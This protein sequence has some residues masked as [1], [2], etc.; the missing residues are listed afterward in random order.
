MANSVGFI[1]LSPL[2]GFRLQVRPPAG[3]LCRANEG[4][5]KGEHLLREATLG[6]YSE[7]NEKQISVARDVG[8]LTD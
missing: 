8:Y 7:T 5:Y 3:K 2:V 4:E 6:N 1:T